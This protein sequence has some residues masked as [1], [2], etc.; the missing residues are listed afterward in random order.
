MIQTAL[1]PFLGCLAPRLPG[2]WEPSLAFCARRAASFRGDAMAVLELP[3]DGLRPGGAQPGLDFSVRL[4]DAGQCLDRAALP[5]AMAALFAARQAG[6]FPAAW[7]PAVWLEYDLRL[8]EERAPIACV[9]VGAEAPAEWW[10]DWLL[11]RLGSGLGAAELGQVAAALALL[12]E[13]ARPLYLFDLSARG[14]PGLRCE[15]AAEPG[16]LPGWLA[17][18]G[19]GQQ[20]AE[21]E[22]L[23]RLWQ[24][25]DRPHVSLD[26][27]AGGWRPRVGLENSFR[28]Q[29]PAEARWRT[30]LEALVA[31]GLAKAEEAEPLLAWPAVATPSATA[32]W[33]TDAA[34]KKLPGWLVSCLSHFKLACSPGESIEAKAYLLFQYLRRE[35]RL[36]PTR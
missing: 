14:A 21:L 11:P 24:D 7:L 19:A 5:A 28:G 17:A 3:L 1:D 26:F 32:G 2:H 13:G 30:Q 22:R 8:G 33:P 35:V 29:P 10:R 20:A 15:L 12:P 9:R 6:G 16:V 23:A 27:G 4:E 34:G 18:I 36:W 25:G 31:A